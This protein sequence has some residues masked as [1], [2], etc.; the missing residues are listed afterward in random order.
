MLNII[1]ECPY[2]RLTIIEAF[3]NGNSQGYSFLFVSRRKKR[4]EKKIKKEENKQVSRRNRETERKERS[5]LR[6]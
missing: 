2:K 5:T 6:N 3:K 4:K 1:K